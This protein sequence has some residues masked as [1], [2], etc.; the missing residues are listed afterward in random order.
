MDADIR[1][2]PVAREPHR[3]LRRER[4]RLH[5]R[6]VGKT[7]VQAETNRAHGQVGHHAAGVRRRGIEIRVEIFNLGRPALVQCVLDAAADDVA[8]LRTIEA[9]SCAGDHDVR[10]R[11]GGTRGA[12]EQPLSHRVTEARARGAETVHIEEAGV[13]ADETAAGEIAD[14]CVDLKSEH[15]VGRDAAV[16]TKLNAAEAAIG[17]EVS[18]VACDVGVVRG[19]GIAAMDADVDAI[20]IRIDGRSFESRSHR[21]V[22]RHIRR[23]G[24]SMD[25]R[26]RQSAQNK[27]PWPDHES[28]RPIDCRH[29]ACFRGS[30]Q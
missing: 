3:R 19:P 9:K 6:H 7:I 14:R 5:D 17:T 1:T 8:D 15:P 24:R 12:V 20:P 27:M 2:G 4:R 23:Q 22:D 10:V 25:C 13:C 18:H 11:P 21:P 28:P 29:G 16:E 30:G 26:Q